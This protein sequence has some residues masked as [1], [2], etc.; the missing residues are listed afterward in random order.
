MANT[1][2]W[3]GSSSFASG[4]STPF[5]FYDADT[6]FQT[7]ADKVAVFCARRLGYPLTDIELQDISFYAAFE[8]AVTTYG[9]EVYAFKASENYLSLEGSP[10]GSNLN[11]KLQKPNLGTVIRIAESY[12]SEAGVG[13]TVEYRTGSIQMTKNKQVYD[14]TEFATSQSVDKN[15]IEIKEIFYQSDPAIVRYFDPYA[16]TGTDVQGLLDAFGFGNYTPGINFLLMPINY[17]LAK[18][19]AIDFNDQIRKSNYS[20]ELVNNQIRIFPIPIRDEKLYFKYIFKTDRNVA[21][22]S[23]SMGTGVVTDIST[24]PYENPTYEYINSIGRQWIFEYTLALAKEMLGYVRGKYTTVPIPG[25]EV[26][27]NQNDLISAATAEKTALIERL[28][29]YLDE[30]SRNRLLE[31]KAA[32]S[33]FIQKDLNAVPYTIYIG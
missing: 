23:G 21:V 29:S 24:V 27:L 4:S 8:E 5:G 6:E 31:K 33:E 25:A 28:R 9:N 13:G 22:V 12:G 19:Q 17:D 16:G 14:L 1:P 18:I 2:I 30:T 15:N 32:N 20:F 10:T 3:P 26:T 11:Y 7:D